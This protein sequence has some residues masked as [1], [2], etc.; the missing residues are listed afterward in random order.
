MEIFFVHLSII[1]TSGA[2]KYVGV[3]CALGDYTTNGH[4]IVDANAVPKRKAS[5]SNLIFVKCT[6]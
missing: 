2:K 6:K 3:L 4:V 5:A 1:A